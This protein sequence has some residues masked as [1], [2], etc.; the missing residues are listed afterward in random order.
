MKHFLDSFYGRAG[1][2]W[3][4]ALGILF[5]LL[6]MGMDAN[7]YTLHLLFSVFV[8][9]TLGH[10]WNLMAGYAGLLT[11]GQQVFIGLGGFAQAMVF[12]YTPASIWPA[13]S[14][15]SSCGCSTNG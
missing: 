11:F 15:R 10:A 8:F 9:A 13:S 5:M 1:A 4:L 2:Y 7:A 12:Y 3:A 14:W 6:P